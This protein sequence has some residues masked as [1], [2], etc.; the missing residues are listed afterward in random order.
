MLEYFK[1]N[2]TDPFDLK[3]TGPERLKLNH[4][5]PLIDIYSVRPYP[6]DWLS[7]YV[8]AATRSCCKE[9]SH[10]HRKGDE[11]IKNIGCAF[12]IHGTLGKGFLKNERMI[13][14]NI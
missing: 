5:G 4:S 7:Y 11:T 3:L 2:R 10:S 9:L 1:I 12:K 13:E 8:I 6:D 14:C